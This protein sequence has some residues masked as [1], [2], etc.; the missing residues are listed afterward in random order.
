MADFIFAIVTWTENS[1][2]CPVT[3]WNETE[4]TIANSISHKPFCSFWK[5]SEVP[6][7]HDLLFIVVFHS[8]ETILNLLTCIDFQGEHAKIHPGIA[9]VTFCY[10]Y[11][12]RTEKSKQLFFDY[13]YIF[14]W[15]DATIIFDRRCHFNKTLVSRGFVRNSA[16]AQYFSICDRDIDIGP[17][18]FP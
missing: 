17:T 6:K 18:K 8:Y 10:R 16:C 14:P 12:H 13:L 3:I 9:T 1:I 7:R 11:F 15:H 4:V 2:L 5:C